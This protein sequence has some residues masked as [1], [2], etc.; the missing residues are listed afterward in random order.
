[1]DAGRQSANP[2]RPKMATSVPT[3]AHLRGSFIMLKWALIF[4]V[5]ALI[6]GALGFTGIAAGAAGIAKVLFFVFLV[7]FVVALLAGSAIFRGV[8]K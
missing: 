7:L 5:I 8:R 3:G 1:M 2:E 6:S 4:A